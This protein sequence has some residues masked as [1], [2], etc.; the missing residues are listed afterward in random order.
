MTQSNVL[1][2]QL[3]STEARLKDQTYWTETYQKNCTELKVQLKDQS[4]NLETAV[5]S[6]NEQKVAL[7]TLGAKLRSNRFVAMD[8]R[9]IA[10]SQIDA[11]LAFL[12]Q[13]IAECQSKADQLMLQCETKKAK[14]EQK[15]KT[16]DAQIQSVVESHKATEMESSQQWTRT[17]LQVDACIGFSKQEYQRLK[18]EVEKAVQ[19]SFNVLCHQAEENQQEWEKALATV[20][21]QE[22]ERKQWLEE[23]RRRIQERKRKMDAIEKE[24]AEKEEQTLKRIQEHTATI[25]KVKRTTKERLGYQRGR[26]QW[27][28]VWKKRCRRFWKRQ[29]TF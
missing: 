13:S 11:L 1:E 8:I 3:N 2:E 24:A 22:L 12:D 23:E 27:C 18:E 17:K 10:V 7:E 28:G 5:A 15:E 20:Q 6:L 29:R 26:K 14:R 4:A 9:G 16:M 19:K 21:T 25:L